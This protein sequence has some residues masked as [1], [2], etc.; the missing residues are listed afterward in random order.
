MERSTT[1]DINQFS[2]NTIKQWEYSARIYSFN[3]LEG[4][5]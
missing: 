2:I 4:G 5:D 1:R 3:R